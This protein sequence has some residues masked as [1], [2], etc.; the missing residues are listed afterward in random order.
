M[1]ASVSRMLQRWRIRQWYSIRGDR[2]EEP[3][4]MFL[5]LDL[6][7]RLS[8]KLHMCTSL[9]RLALV[10]GPWEYF[11]SHGRPLLAYLKPMQD[12][13]DMGFQDRKQVLSSTNGIR[14]GGSCRRCG[15]A[16]AAPH[17]YSP[18]FVLG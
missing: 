7:A 12:E 8:E 3:A 18:L 11:E 13:F 15:S 5:P 17:S 14:S 1:K 9:D 10:L 2:L 4:E 6:I 16:C